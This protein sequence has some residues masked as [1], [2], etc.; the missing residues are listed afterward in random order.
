MRK[1][2]ILAVAGLT[3]LA[4]VGTASADTIL[5]IP[6]SF[7]NAVLGTA[8]GDL[9]VASPAT[10]P[11]TATA[12]VDESNGTFTIAQNAISF[13]TASFM[14]P[15]PG[16]ATIALAGPATGQ[17]NPA[18]GQL[19][20]TADFQATVNVTGLGMCTVDT[21]PQTYSTDQTNLYAGQRFPITPDGSGFV[22]GAGAISGGW[23]SLA[24]TSGPACALLGSALGGK[25]S[26]WISRNV[27]PPT[28]AALTLASSPAK[29]KVT[30]GKSVTLN[31]T[32]K[33]TG[34]SAASSVTV[35]AVAPKALKLR[36]PKCQTIV[37]IAGGSSTVAKFTFQASKTA[38]GNLAVSFTAKASGVT[39]AATAKSS[40]KVAAAKKKKKH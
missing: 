29:A 8:A 26:L 27:S 33:N 10:A 22:T 15:V 7:N 24:G 23:A 37:T 16:T 17:L 21:G 39:K 1:F 25:G 20:F 12:Q 40:V 2:G 5:P 3:S 11:I 19:G 4:L 36:G 38:K 32:V 9:V 31:E 35:C 28:P 34:G 13:P 30:A 18:T 6:L 14:T